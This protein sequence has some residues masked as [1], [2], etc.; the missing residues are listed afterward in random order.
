MVKKGKYIGFCIPRRSY[1][2]C[3]PVIRTFCA[4]GAAQLYVSRGEG[5]RFH[6]SSPESSFREHFSNFETNSSSSARQ[7]RGASCGRQRAAVP[8]L[9]L[10]TKRGA[11]HYSCSSTRRR[12]GVELMWQSAA[13]RSSKRTC[14]RSAT[15][16]KSGRASA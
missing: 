9:D 3:P 15:S 8:G 13:D 1:L 5:S 11:G 14:T 7:E 12:G 10:Q 16:S 4:G 6:S 2:I